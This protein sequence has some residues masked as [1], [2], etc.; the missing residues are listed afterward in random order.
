[1][2][3]LGFSVDQLW[4]ELAGLSVATSIAELMAITFQVCNKGFC[5]FFVYIKLVALPCLAICYRQCPLTTTV[6]QPSE[7]NCVLAICGP[8]NNGGDGLVAARHLYHFGYKPFLESLSV[9]FLSEDELPAD[10]SEDF[11]ILIDAMFGFSFH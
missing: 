6:Y 5:F 11:D 9:S 2:G 10:L 1:M 7:Y 4:F 8:G 3:P